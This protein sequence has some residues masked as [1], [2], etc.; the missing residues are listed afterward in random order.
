MWTY[1]VWTSMTKN[2]YSVRS[3]AASTVKQVGGEDTP[4]L[5]AQELA[6]RRSGSPWGRAEAMATQQRSDG[7][8]R[9]PHPELG[10]FSLDPQASPSRVLTSYSQDEVA[11]VGCD[12][13]S[14]A[15]RSVAVG[16]LPAHQLTVPTKQRLRPDQERGPSLPGECSAERSQV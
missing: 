11:N 10:E 12:R 13:R 3:H 4:G 15:D 6:P 8:R 5:A 1:L 9:D 2:T 16:P 7:R 14:T